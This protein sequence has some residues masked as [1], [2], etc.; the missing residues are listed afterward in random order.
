MKELKNQLASEVFY[1]QK[2]EHEA[3]IEFEDII[4]SA[5]VT[6]EVY[7]NLHVR[8]VPLQLQLQPMASES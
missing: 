4:K 2:D 5:W 1:Q 6:R 8:E 7:G 3:C